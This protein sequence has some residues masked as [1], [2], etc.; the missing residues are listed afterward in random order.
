M[1]PLSRRSILGLLAA[2]IATCAFLAWRENPD[3][4]RGIWEELLWLLVGAMVTTFILESLLSRDLDNRRKDDAVF[5]FRIIAGRTLD[6]LH[7]MTISTEDTG[8]ESG[9]ALKSAV[10]SPALFAEAA[11]EL[12]QEIQAASSLNTGC[13]CLPISA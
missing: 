2:A 5:G 6:I 3:F 1:I 11:A 7:L 4:Q 12:S 9:R 10:C 13:I 8:R